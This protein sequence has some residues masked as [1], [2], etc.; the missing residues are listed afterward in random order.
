MAD[1]PDERRP[2]TPLYRPPDGKPPVPGGPRGQ[3]PQQRGRMPRFP[4]SRMFWVIV[5]GLLAL[6]YL[7]VALFAPGKAQSVTIPYSAPTGA[8]GFL[9]QINKG[10]VSKVKTQ[11]TSIEGVFKQ[12]VRYPN[13]KAD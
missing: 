1:P 2:R 11:G 13:D 3:Q 9:Q 6:N 10:N 5:I 12:S 8:P 7:S 4:G